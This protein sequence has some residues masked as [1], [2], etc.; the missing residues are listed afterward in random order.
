MTH[1]QQNLLVE[2]KFFC[3]YLFK[4]YPL[5]IRVRPCIKTIHV[6]FWLNLNH[7]IL[8]FEIYVSLLNCK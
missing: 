6:I 5:Q 2:L 8:P 3:N 7:V 1:S 4:N